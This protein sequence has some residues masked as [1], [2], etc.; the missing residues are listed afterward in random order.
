MTRIAASDVSNLRL[1]R[2][3]IKIMD[4]S[5]VTGPG[6]LRSIR[7]CAGRLRKE[8][9][10]LIPLSLSD[11]QV[12]QAPEAGGVCRH[13]RRRCA[14]AVISL[15]ALLTFVQVDCGLLVQ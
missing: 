10:R 6:A 8:R 4:L 7:K 2:Q 14:L 5:T 9:Q 15:A 12:W 13:T 11:L 1:S 3:L